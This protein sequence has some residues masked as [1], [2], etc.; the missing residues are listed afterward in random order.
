MLKKEILKKIEKGLIV[1]CYA[2][3]D[4]NEYMGSPDVMASVALSCIHGGAAAIRTNLENVRAI[5]KRINVPVFGIKKI[6]ANKNV[7]D[8]TNSDFRITPTMKEVEELVEAGVDA[9][10]IDATIRPRYDSLTLKE[11][12]QQIKLKYDVLIV[13]DISTVEEGIAAFEFGADMIGTTLSGYTPY[14]K[15]PIK[16]GTIPSPEPDYDIIRQL[17][18][19]G[20]TYIIAEGRITNGSK[21]GKALQAGAHSVVIGTSITEPRKI[22]KTILNEADNI[23]R[24]N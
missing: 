21:M 9:I 12:I 7:I 8:M 22:V 15:N 20:V 4:F 16:F 14:S 6:Y 2:G 19:A 3:K 10:A 1:S 17:R 5:K 13:A 18:N 11:F 23:E 24:G